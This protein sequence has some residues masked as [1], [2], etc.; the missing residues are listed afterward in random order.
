MASSATLPAPI[1]AP[2]DVAEMALRLGHVREAH[3]DAD[4]L[5][6]YVVHDPA[7]VFYLTHFHNYV[8]ERPFVLVVPREGPLRFVVPSSRNSTCACARWATSSSSSTSSSRRPGRSL[9]GP[10]ARGVGGANRVGVE[11][12]CPLQVADEIAG[13]AVRI[14]VVDDVRM[15]KTD[16]EIGRIAHAA[17]S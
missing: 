10:H 5:D 11:S 15:V 9:V 6:A 2:P 14:D 13:T 7:N 4:V 16:Y 12:L 1:T 17:R 3:G 8:H